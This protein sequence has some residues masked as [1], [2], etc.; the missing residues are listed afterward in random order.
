MDALV[1]TGVWN[2]DGKRIVS[3][4]EQAAAQAATAQFP[5][6]VAGQLS[7]IGD[8]TALQM[9]V[10]QFT[11]EHVGKVQAFFDRFVPR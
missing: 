11:A 1:A 2:A 8:E 10:H 5:P 9:A 6:S 3:D 4:I 7:A